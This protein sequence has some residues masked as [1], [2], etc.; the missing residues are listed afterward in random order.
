MP[1][2]DEFKEERA[3]VKNRSFK[4]KCSYFWDYYKWHVIGGAI[5]LFAVISLIHTI[6]SQKE[7]VFYAALLNIGQSLYSEEYRKEFEEYLGID[8]SKEKA[9]LDIMPL[10]LTVMDDATVST[11]Q[12]VMVYVSAGDL[13]VIIAD[14][15]VTNHYAYID[16]MMDLRDFLSEEELEKYEPYFYYVDRAKIQKS[17]GETPETPDYPEDPS[18]PSGMEEPVPVGI[19]IDHCKKF[20]EANYFPG[21]TYFTVVTNSSHLDVAHIFLDYIWEDE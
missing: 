6:L 9:Y 17:N 19:R 21:A 2:M 5:A 14:L 12:K 18:D 4:E 20:G 8:T 7:T 15:P 11:T 1:L 10:E 16:T 3:E 13:D